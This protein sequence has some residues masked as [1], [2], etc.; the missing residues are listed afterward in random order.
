MINL[1]NIK[2]LFINLKKSTDRLKFIQ[3][4][5]DKTELKYERIEAIDG[6]K[7]NQKEK[8]FFGSRKNFKCMSCVKENVYKRVGLYLSQMKCL[9]YALENKYDGVIIF[10]DD[11]FMLSD[12]N[13]EVEIPEDC[14]ILYLG[15]GLFN[16]KKNNFDKNTIHKNEIV[17]ID[18]FKLV[19]AYAYI[20]P[21]FE[22]I[23]ELI[24]ILSYNKMTTFDIS[25]INYVQSL[26]R[27]YLYT[28][29]LIQHNDDF[30]S[31]IVKTWNTVYKIKS[32]L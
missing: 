15:G 16:D 27:S 5:L 10:E 18:G 29:K 24:Q 6:L 2:T 9:K 17:K 13:I 11:V 1:K 21:S 22:A 14:L 8:D 30:D 23:K 28:N 31:T 12:F 7:F 32:I 3:T 25:L 26:G 4:Q 19:G 20:V